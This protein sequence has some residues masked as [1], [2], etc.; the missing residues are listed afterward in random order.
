MGKPQ[1]WGHPQKSKGI[2]CFGA[3]RWRFALGKKIIEHLGVFQRDTLESWYAYFSTGKPE[4]FFA[5]METLSP[6]HKS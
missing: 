5:L 1:A 6:D 2:S 4:H 3:P